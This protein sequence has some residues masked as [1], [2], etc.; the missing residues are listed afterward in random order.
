M[1]KLINLLITI[2]FCLF[3]HLAQS[4]NDYFFPSGITF[5]PGIPSPKAFLGYNTGDFHT[6]HDRMVSYFQ[7]LARVSDLAD[8]QIIG[9]TNEH[10]PQVVL[11]ITSAN[12]HQNLENIRQN[13][14]VIADP[15]KALPTLEN[16][17]VIILLGY[18]VHGNEPS[19]MEAAML[20][21]YYLLAAQGQEV[22]QYL[23]NAVIFIDPNF[24]P[25]GRDRHT[26]WANMHKAKNLSADPL[27]REHNEVWPGGR[28]NHYWFDLN[29]DWLPLAQVESRNRLRFYHQWLPNVVT[30]YHEMG[31][32][33]TYFFEPTK[34]Y[35]SENP[36]VPRSN[37][38]GL[39]TLF[40]KYFTKALDEIGSL[41]FTKEVYD[42]SYP[43]YGSTYPD[44]HGGLGMVFEQASSRGHLQNTTTEP[45][46]FAFTIRNHLRTSIATLQASVE[47]REL[48]LRHQKQFFV[49]ALKS[50]KQSA[51]KYYLFGDA[52][53][54]GRTQAFLKLLLQHNIKTYPLR[55]DVSIDGQ[56]FAAGSAYAVPSAQAQYKMVQTFFEPVTTFSDSVF[57]DASSWTVALAFGMP[58]SRSKQE[59]NLGV[60]LQ[61][62]NL[63]KELP[64]IGKA[65]YAYVFEWS[66]Y[67]APKALYYLLSKGVHAKVAQKE[68]VLMTTKGEQRF[69]YGAIMIAVA[70]QKYTPDE[71]HTWVIEA[72]QLA[73]IGIHSVNS[74]R[75]LQG[76]D[77]GSA[78][79]S[80][81]QMPKIAM[82]IGQGTS[83]YEAGE[84]WHLLDT[85]FDMPFSKVDVG[86]FKRMALEKFNTL[87][88]VSG[89]YETLDAADIKK[90]KDWA[91]EGGTLILQ[92][93]AVNWAMNKE[94][95]KEKKIEAVK[96]EEKNTQRFDYITARD[97][98]GAK[99]IGGSVYSCRLDNTHPLGYGY[100]FR[101]INV[102]RN[103]SLFIQPSE[104]LYSTVVQYDDNPL[105]DGYVHS[106]N[107]ALIKNSASVLASRMG[108]GR[109]VLFID[110][111]N[112]RGFWYGTNKLF[113]NALFFGSQINIP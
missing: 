41:Y 67:Y 80:T 79:F 55:Q 89:N 112:F 97:R 42:N 45:I 66:D 46:Y 76:I 40:A 93:T 102:Y 43:G 15:D 34:P 77:L 68:S 9:Y 113:M 96:K 104:N 21:A 74:G 101:K 59:P 17:P 29:R 82:L 92:R 99:A 33:S 26:H 10:R 106:E 23:D 73:G 78:H 90:I 61:L 31:S 75:S 64:A 24:N 60:V 22:K 95:I 39:N 28:T 3:F 37:Y 30:D 16:H 52:K 36:L 62:E 38:D 81:V 87:I 11:T 70:D 44:I 8:F 50:G 65:N 91:G 108:R 4:Q 109:A 14:M 71:I 20:T 98:A 100:A 86:D 12:N 88:L 35:G 105:L 103:H 111:P 49:D 110:N 69:G 2:L 84:I 51:T 25:D 47:N 83:A 6:R 85:R 107:L 53:D 19:S 32:N 5:N 57:Y 72:A 63:E 94:L 48:L 7:E 18:N 58:Y 27:D 56:V 1:S 54:N 13:H